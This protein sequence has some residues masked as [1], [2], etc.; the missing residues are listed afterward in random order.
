MNLELHLL[1]NFSPSNLNRDDT[2]APKDCMFGGFRRARISSQAFKRAIRLEFPRVG[3]DDENL[4]VRTR[5]LAEHTIEALE[6]RGRH[7]DQATTAAHAAIRGLGLDLDKAGHSQYLLFVSK[8]AVDGLT[9]V[10]DTHFDTLVATDAK[11]REAKAAAADIENLHQ[12]LDA[13]QAVDIAMFGRMIADMP[14]KNIDAATQVAQ[15]ISTHAAQVEF[16]YFTAVD[17]LLATD[18]SGAGMIGTIEYNSACFYRYLNL[19]TSQL[20]HNLD[21]DEELARLGTRAFLQATISAIPT[22]KQTTM[23]AQN[24]PSAILAVV[25]NSGF[26]SLANAFEE[27]VRPTHDHGLVTQSVERLGNHYHNLKNVYG[28]DQITHDAAVTVG[29]HPMPNVQ[30]ATNVTE[31][32]DATIAAIWA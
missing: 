14:D 3:V 12:V 7:K 5:L 32:I 18:E 30:A 2:G 21:G 4:G 13:R 28:E 16:D 1:Q 26:W 31:L 17:D 19:S 29:D 10:V 27:P 9:E 22:G 23:A 24:P 11:K 8:N 15:A 20:L 6:Q 25:R